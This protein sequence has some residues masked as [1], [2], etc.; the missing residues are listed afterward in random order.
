MEFIFER[1]LE[2][3]GDRLG[4]ITIAKLD[5]FRMATV[6]AYETIIENE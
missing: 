5:G 6:H 4:E 1:L 2:K 3:F